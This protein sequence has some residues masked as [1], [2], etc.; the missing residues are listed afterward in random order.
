MIIQNKLLFPVGLIQVLL[1]SLR[2]GDGLFH[3]SRGHPDT[4]R[5]HEA[6]IPSTETLL[7]T[8]FY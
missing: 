5:E 7:L 8:Y 3:V 4:K 1:F 6:N 2:K